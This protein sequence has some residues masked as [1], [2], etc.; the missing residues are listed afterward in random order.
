MKILF[1]GFLVLLCVSVVPCSAATPAQQQD[2]QGEIKPQ[3]AVGGFLE[4]AVG[5]LGTHS[6]ASPADCANNIRGAL[7]FGV[8]GSAFLGDSVT[9]FVSG[10]YI[11]FWTFSA[12]AG[13]QVTVTFSSTPQ[14]LVTIQDFSSGAVLFSSS[15]PCGGLVRSCSF[16]VTIPN[17]AQYFLG[18]GGQSTGNYTVTL[19]SGGSP[20]PS[21]QANLTP[22]TP[23]GWSAPIVVSTT[24]G[25]NTDSPVLHSTDTLYVD[26]AICNTGTASTGVGYSN[27]LFLDGTLIRTG[28]AQATDVNHY[29]FASDVVVG[30]LSVGTHSLVV[31]ADSTNAVAESNES[32]NQ[33]TKTFT[34]TGASSVC[35]PNA[36]TACLN[37]NRFMVTVTWVSLSGR[38]GDEQAATASGNGQAVSLTGDT[39]YFWFFSSNN[40]ELVIKVVDGRSFNNFFWVF[41]GALSNVQYTITVTDTLTGAVKVYNNPQG[42]LASV[43]DTAAFH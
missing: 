6:I 28:S 20:P 5:V 39:A 41:Y 23:S 10:V 11:D 24:T 2:V 32:D 25:A 15:T 7:T 8:A 30:P 33:Y 1:T 43:A 42:N 21:G 3:A 38:T 4:K 17:T 19:T 35:T 26:Y 9:C 29:V 36:T 37:A 12:S 31:V 40:V 16:S 13:Q 18:I 34:V 14:I 22:C 27:Q